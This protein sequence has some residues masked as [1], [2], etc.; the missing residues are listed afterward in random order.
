G[1]RLGSSPENELCL[2]GLAPQHARLVRL[3]GGWWVELLSGSGRLNGV[4]L[5]RVSP[6][7]TGDRL[8]LGAVTLELARLEAP[9]PPGLRLV[10]GR[11]GSCDLVIDS[12]MVS[13]RHAELVGTERGF[14]LR[15]LGSS[16]G[17]FLEGRRILEELLSPG[18]EVYIGPCRLYFD[19]RTLAEFDERGMV[20]VDAVD[21]IYH[22]TTSPRPLLN[23]IT[24]S[25]RPREF[26]A[27]VGT[28]GAGKSTL[29]RCLT[30]QRVP[31]RG[32]ILYNGLDVA[33]N[34]DLFRS[35]LGYVPQDDIVHREL[36]VEA[37][38]H[39]AARLR[40]PSDTE[41]AEV[42]RRIDFVLASVGLAHRRQARIDT[43]SGGERKRVSVAVELL[44]EPGVFFL[45]EPTSGLDPG[46]EKRA[47]ELF[48]QLARQGRTVILIT[49]ATQNIVLCDKV[50]FL[51]PGGRVVYYGPPREALDF[52][53]VEDF[54]DI[55]LKVL[56]HGL[57][58]EQR[59]RASPLH[60]RYVE[61]GQPTSPDRPEV[62]SR[63]IPRPAPR[64]SLWAGFRQFTVLLE[65]YAHQLVCDRA[66]LALLLGQAPL[67][68]LILAFLFE[69]DLFALRQTFEKGKFP[70]QEGPTV[71]FTMMVSCLLFG[72][73]NSCREVVKE[74]SIFERERLV[75]LQLFPYLM[76]KV[77]LL[78]LLGLVQAAILQGVVAWRIQLGL[79]SAGHLQLY[80]FLA[81]ACLG[82]VL[83]GLLLS[84]LCSSA[85]QAMSL[86]SV[87]LILQIV[88]SG[89]FVKPEGMA[90]P[91]A[92]L[93][94]LSVSR[95]VFAGLGTTLNLN[96][97][98]EELGLGW[99]TGDF[100]LSDLQVWSVLAP[101]LGLYL[102]ASW[103]L[104]G[105]DRRKR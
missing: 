58:W 63:S 49:H 8:Q 41:A 91:I 104:L 35:V 10:V 38:L 95:W 100:Y 1:L 22:P 77:I 18:Q 73:V 82:G 53:G 70:I 76:S 87:V 80:G 3:D 78:A 20:R 59:F 69:P 24:L 97:R 79:D 61:A 7:A 37:A 50:L 90:G 71:L 99:I 11:S 25:V 51:A 101:L 45:D 43:L 56:D 4:R 16:N 65:R 12:P 54:A 98:F 52:F 57:E 6:L 83:M 33:E 29:L 68:G 66:N 31:T 13:A 92:F 105:W 102:A 2:D 27:V 30:G 15:D 19:G 17:T 96:S 28:S 46:L 62:R 5:E 48:S 32:H 72:V 81:G 89:A 9:P 40:L 14:L 44:T 85:E 34:M 39:Y 60:H 103:L 47:M 36:P 75:N 86:V 93:S 94:V 42:A 84:C 64:A 21:V 74:R 88:L 55:Y 23:H 26:V 67:I